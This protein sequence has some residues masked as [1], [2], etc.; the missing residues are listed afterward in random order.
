M[1]IEGALLRFFEFMP[2]KIMVEK[3]LEGLNP[4]RP[5]LCSTNRSISA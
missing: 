5:L 4:G 2:I 1:E 3:I